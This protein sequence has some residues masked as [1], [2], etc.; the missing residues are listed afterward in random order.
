VV[1]LWPKATEFG[2]ANEERRSVSSTVTVSDCHLER[3]IFSR[4]ISLDHPEVLEEE[5][6]RSR[7]VL[8]GEDGWSAARI[9][10]EVS[11]RRRAVK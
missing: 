9:E 11:S 4:M 6:S 3:P 5:W 2:F 1:S 10:E 8:A 7:D